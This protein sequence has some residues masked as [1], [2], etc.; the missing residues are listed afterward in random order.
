[1]SLSDVLNLIALIII[2]LLAVVIAQ[3]LQSRSEKRKDKMQIFK[4][5]MT[6]RNLGWSL[7]KVYCLNLIDVVFADDKKVRAAWKDLYDKYCVDNPDEQQKKKMQ[8]SEYKLLEAIAVSLGYKD[9]ITWETIQNPY[10]PNG[11]ID[12]LNRQNNIQ[13]MYEYIMT[14]VS[15]NMKESTNKMEDKQ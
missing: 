11:L 1:M 13:Q 2:P 12:Q 6:S 15:Q 7:E 4:T 14:K 5:L 8:Q 9:K 3:W 10:I